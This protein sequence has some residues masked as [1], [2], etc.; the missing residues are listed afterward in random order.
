LCNPPIGIREIFKGESVVCDT[1]L[2][3]SR[4]EKSALE[5][6]GK[7]VLS[8]PGI[9]FGVLLGVLFGVLLGVLVN[10]LVEIMGEVACCGGLFFLCEL[11]R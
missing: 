8:F 10:A 5:I 11:A 4:F 7:F 6:V 9:R 3:L 1:P 2:I